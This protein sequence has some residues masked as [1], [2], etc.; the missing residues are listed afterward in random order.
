MNINKKRIRWGKILLTFV[1]AL[2]VLGAVVGFLGNKLA[3]AWEGDYWTTEYDGLSIT[4]VSVSQDG[5]PIEPTDDG[6]GGYYFVTTNNTDPLTVGMV[7]N[8]MVPEDS[9]YYYAERAIRTE[10]YI[11]LRRHSLRSISI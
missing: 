3:T 9:Y 7:V 2:G 8:G 5:V 6:E 4:V 10:K 1:V 11:S